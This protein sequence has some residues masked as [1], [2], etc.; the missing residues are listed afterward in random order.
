MQP[1]TASLHPGPVFAQSPRRRPDLISHHSGE[2]ATKLSYK[3]LKN[4][5]VAVLIAMWAWSFAGCATP[6]ATRHSKKTSL[7]PRASLS[8]YR[9]GW[10]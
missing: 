2:M 8:V 1:P 10:I 9:C 6:R 4:R 3:A 7:P 5:A